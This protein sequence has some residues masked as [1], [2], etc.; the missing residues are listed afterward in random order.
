MNTKL[1]AL[2]VDDEPD[3]LLGLKEL[4]ENNLPEFSKIETAENAQNALEKIIDSTPDILFLDIQMPIHDGFWLADKLSKLKINTDIIFV[5][6]YNEYAIE[7]IRHSAFDFLV[8]PVDPDELKNAVNRYLQ[9]INGQKNTLKEK[10]SRLNDFFNRERLKFN[11][12]KGV[13]FLNADEI[14][15]CEAQHN[16]TLLHL[17]DGKQLLITMQLGKTEK[18]LK[19]K[20]FLRISRSALINKSFIEMYNRKRRTVILTDTLQKYELKTSFTGSKRLL[21]L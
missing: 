11:S 21:K 15:Y 5:T 8:K 20:G 9:L 18:I 6:A 14:I 16:Y 19:D 1:T 4:I 12:Q 10:V 17:I 7:A 3:A 2:I 13:T